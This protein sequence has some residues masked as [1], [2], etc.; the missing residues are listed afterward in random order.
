MT[1]RLRPR[2]HHPKA[3]AGRRA[4][5]AGNTEKAAGGLPAFQVSRIRRYAA[6]RW[7][8]KRRAPGD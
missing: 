5:S 4:S 3:R 6:L 2:G 7:Q 8:V 1:A